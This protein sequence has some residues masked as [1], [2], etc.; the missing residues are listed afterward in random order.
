MKRLTAAILTVILLFQACIPVSAAKR[1]VVQRTYGANYDKWM[2]D[3][4]LYGIDGTGGG[5]YQTF[6]QSQDPIY[7]T[8][9]A[10][11][12]DN[13]P[14]ISIST[15]WSVFLNDEYRNRFYNEQEYIYEVILMDFLKYRAN[16]DVDTDALEG[17]TLKF[18]K[19]LYSTL[20][21]ELSNNTLNYIDNKLS[22]EEATRIWKNAKVAEGIGD[23]TDYI[24]DTVKAM[25]EGVAGCLALKERKANVITL[26]RQSG[27]AAGK[28]TDYK[29]AVKEIVAALN[30]T[31]NYYETKVTL[32]YLW[33]QS[34][35]IASDFLKGANP[36][37]GGIELYAAGLDVLFNTS[38][39]ASNNL[40]LALL[41]TMD[42]YMSIA[43][44]DAASE[45]RSNKTPANARKFRECFE[46]YV[47][48]QMFGNEYAKQWLDEY[49]D[50]ESISNAVRKIL[51]K[52]N[53]K[54]AQE[55]LKLC[56]SQTNSRKKILKGINT[57]TD[58]YEKKYPITKTEIIPDPT[59]KLSATSVSIQKGKT[60]TLKATVTGTSRKVTW[61]SSNSSVA[62]V[63]STGKVTAKAAGK[64]VISAS[65]NGKTAKCTVT[66]K[67]APSLDKKA[68][69]KKYVSYIKAFHT[70]N[71]NAYMEWVYEGLVEPGSSEPI[72]YFSF[73]DIDGDGIDECMVRFSFPSS[74]MTTIPLGSR[75]ELYTIQ[76]EKVKKVVEQA[77]YGSGRYPLV[78]V[79][80]GDKLVQFETSSRKE[81]FTF[82][83]GAL[84]SRAAYSCEYVPGAYY[85]NGVKTTAAKFTA[86]LN[87][88]TKGKVGYPMYRYSTANLNKFL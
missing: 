7:R 12:L 39:S 45:Y 3:T 28:N 27:K 2:A 19:Q 26:L 10:A 58:I 77:E 14:L 1:T 51:N 83:N 64:A 72:T 33:T 55:L 79:Y 71:F 41:Y 85:V 88:M 17:N 66:V 16:L 78:G 52:K 38:N 35:D 70:K 82:K 56:N 81:F 49:L 29:T 67:N 22:V 30:S 48:F 43:L 5:W 23:L 18:T 69:H 31:E 4:L 75:T 47:E 73:M 63:S 61:K 57:Y 62:S 74:S 9:G 36:W 15:A 8:L 21:G 76:G 34:L 46:A 80:K 60:Y 11:V 42:C 65:A 50:G 13:K 44:T 68:Q 84:G 6:R 25:I 32:G 87:K 37:L 54:T 20:A 40:K 86:F 53:I 59:I 24:E